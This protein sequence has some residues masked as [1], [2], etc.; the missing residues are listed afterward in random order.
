MIRIQSCSNCYDTVEIIFKVLLWIGSCQYKRKGHERSLMSWPE[1]P[2]Y[3]PELIFKILMS[4][5]SDHHCL[6]ESYCR[7]QKYSV[8]QE[9]KRWRHAILGSS[10]N[11]FLFQSM[12]SITFIFW[13]SWGKPNHWT[14]LY[15]TLTI[16][17]CVFRPDLINVPGS[18]REQFSLGHPVIVVMD[19]LGYNRDTEVDC[20]RSYL[21][22]EWER[23]EKMRFKGDT[24]DFSG[25][26]ILSLHPPYLPHQP[27]GIDCGVYT[28]VFAERTLQ[29]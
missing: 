29:R 25:E 7:S 27:N 12:K 24:P 20:M 4:L 19:S 26:G 14:V 22:Q 2:E 8:L 5:Q 10:R 11:T 1:W 28:L 16:I 21:G 9:N 15:W 17:F 3:I 13:L 6:F 18:V 23:K